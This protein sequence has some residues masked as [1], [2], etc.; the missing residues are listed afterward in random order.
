MGWCAEGR[1]KVAKVTRQEGRKA[2]RQ[3]GR[4]GGRQESGQSVQGC[5][6]DAC[7]QDPRYKGLLKSRLSP[8]MLRH[9]AAVVFG[10]GEMGSA[11]MG[12]LQISVF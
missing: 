10:K 12:S 7:A 9:C 11:L 6:A 5:A 2:G 8:E 3:E 4:E 1:G